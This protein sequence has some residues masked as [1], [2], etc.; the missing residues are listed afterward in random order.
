[1]RA[2]SRREHLTV[3]LRDALK[4]SCFALA[5]TVASLTPAPSQAAVLEEF[6]TM[7]VVSPLAEG[8]QWFLRADLEWLARN[9]DVV[10][11]PENFVTDFASIPRL[12]W[13][14]L[15]RWDGYGPA[16]VVHD[17][18]YWRQPGS[19]RQA[20][21]FML[22]AMKDQD[23]GWATRSIVYAGVRAGGW[24]AWWS[25]SRS[26]GNGYRRVIPAAEVPDEATTTWRDLRDRIKDTDASE[27]CEL[28]LE[29]PAAT[30]S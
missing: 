28:P 27:D 15:P 3:Q 4:P 18:L 23:V 30:A 2:S 21:L 17:Y 6:T 24:L 16:A 26:K 9:G 13:A 22:E 11:V 7:V 10:C 29:P 1:M 19:R 8:D 25:N 14:V 12:L 20:D 5:W